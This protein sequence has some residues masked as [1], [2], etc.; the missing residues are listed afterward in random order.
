M[1]ERL[2]GFPL[3]APHPFGGSRYARPRESGHPLAV[4][5][6]ERPSINSVP[7][8]RQRTRAVRIH[9]KADDET[10]AMSRRR[11]DFKPALERRDASLNHSQTEAETAVLTV[12]AQSEL[13][14]RFENLLA[15]LR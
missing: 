8:E 4:R 3:P 7:L 11:L 1:E 14:E 2:N 13:R 5:R 15:E 9:R 6:S 10:R 12:A